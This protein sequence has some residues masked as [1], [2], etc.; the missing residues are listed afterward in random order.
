MFTIR[1]ITLICFAFVSGT[2]LSQ[3][4]KS[5]II[6]MHLHAYPYDVNGPEQVAFCYPLSTII[7]YMDPKDDG[8]KLFMDKFSNPECDNPLWS[9]KSNEELINGIAQ[10]LEKNNVTAIA[11]GSPDLVLE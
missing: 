2:T 6:D 3:E 10:Q 4:S 7:P 8:M 9:A 1:L 5:P 11:S